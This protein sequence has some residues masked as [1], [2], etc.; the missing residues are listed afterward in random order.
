MRISQIVLVV[1]SSVFLFSCVSSKKYKAEQTRYLQLNDT[2]TQLQGSLKTCENEKAEANR[3]KALLQTDVD[4]LNK[5]VTFLK[6]H[7]TQ[8]L[9][10]LQ[11]LSVIS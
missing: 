5:Q 8:T 1:F 10:Q 7:N 11:D 9:K 4:N 3:Q 2:Y 6:E